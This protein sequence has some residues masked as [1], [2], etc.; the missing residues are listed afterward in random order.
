MNQDPKKLAPQA[1]SVHVRVAEDQTA[2]LLD[3]GIGAAPH[4]A[5]A[6]TV[7]LAPALAKALAGGLSA[8]VDKCAIAIPKGVKVTQ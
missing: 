3:L 2:V 8:A 7:Q 5:L 6:L 1:F 4:G